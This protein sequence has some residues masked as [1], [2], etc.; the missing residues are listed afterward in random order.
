MLGGSDD[1]NL[2]QWPAEKLIPQLDRIAAAGGNLIRNTMSDRKDKGFEIYAFARRDDGK[3]DLDRWNEE[4]W[5]RFER[6]L[7]ETAKRDIF[8]QIEIWDRFDYSDSGTDR[9]WGKHPYNPANNV[10]YTAEESGLAREYPDH[11]GTNR[12]P[13]FFTTPYQ[14]NDRI[15]LKYQEKFVRRMLD[16]SLKYDHV[17]YCMDNETSGEEAWSRYWAEFVR[18]RAREKNKTVFLTEMWYDWNLAAERHKRTFDHPEL[19]GF[20]DVSQNNHNKGSD[21]WTNFLKVRDSLKE[22]PRPIDS[23]KTCGATGNKFGDTDQDGI[24]RFMKQILAGAAAARFHRPDSGLGINDKAV[25]AIRSVRLLEAIVPLWS[26]EMKSGF[27]RGDS[28]LNAYAAGMFVTGVVVFLPQN[29]SVTMDLR[30]FSGKLNLHW[31]DIDRGVAKP[32]ESIQS[33]RVLNLK[34]PA[35]GNWLIA[36]VRPAS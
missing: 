20:V 28:H 2:F 5:E 26:L 4:Y 25:A 3:Y 34:A 36:I 14:R 31:I 33:N 12:Q 16:H 1:D 21:H 23:I 10:N 17:L 22:K 11:P 29:D 30:A 19:Y 15:V 9:R 35:K 6:L 7:A 13:F 27:L 24:E 32:V 18:D 8:V